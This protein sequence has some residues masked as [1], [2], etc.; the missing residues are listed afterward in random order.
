MIHLSSVTKAV[1]LMQFFICARRFLS[2]LLLIS[3]SFSASGG[4]CF[5]ITAFPEYHHICFIFEEY[6]K[7]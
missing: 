6:D 4:L 3:P 1:P 2:L 5:V 7:Y